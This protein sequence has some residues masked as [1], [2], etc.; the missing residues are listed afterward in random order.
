M[1]WLSE[2]ARLISARLDLS[3]ATKATIVL[4][5][6]LLA[7]A[8]AQQTRASVRHLVVTGG[9]AALFFLPI[10]AVVLP[11]FDI[12]L[13]AAVG[14][15]SSGSAV[16]SFAPHGLS[17][18]SIVTTVWMLGVM[19]L[20]TLLVI[21]LLRL[22][23]LR[24][25][26]LPWLEQ[27]AYVRSLALARDI[28]RPVDVMLHESITTPFTCGLRRSAILLPSVAREWSD[29]DLE[30]ALVHELEHVRRADWI[31]QMLARI[32]CIAYWPH[33]LIWVAWRRLRL[34]AER[35]CDDAVV[36]SSESTEYANQ[37]VSLARQLSASRALPS[38]ALAHRS[39]LAT[40]VAS[41]LDGRR[42]RG[43]AGSLAT[44][45]V[46]TAAGIVVLSLAPLRAVAEAPVS[47]A[48]TSTVVMPTDE[49]SE[50]IPQTPPRAE[51]P[52]V[53]PS[54][55][56]ADDSSDRSTTTRPRVSDRR[57][58]ESEQTWSS[59]EVRSSS[60]SSPAGTKTVASERSSSG[61]HSSSSS[62]SSDGRQTKQ[63]PR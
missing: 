59:R 38:L 61:S 19:V 63:R 10:V 22:R 48:A 18:A 62:S 6:C 12:P 53:E 29:S 32:V 4:A 11:A 9:F 40:R 44:A 30:R 60:G 31:T 39:D 17:L 51:R 55:Q 57:D 46:L 49:P 3:I 33:P 42:R 25:T 2:S 1:T 23:G 26:A 20:L 56:W 47:A 24:R 58:T 50:S 27:R 13:A 8:L 28:R 16:D 54:T 36:V 35:A 37:L 45:S 43:R 7:L 41:L 21:D 14:N 52:R 34:E 5:V 15:A